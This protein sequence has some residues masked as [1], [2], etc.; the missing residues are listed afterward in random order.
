MLVYRYNRHLFTAELLTNLI[1]QHTVD[2]TRLN[3]R[4]ENSFWHTEPSY[5]REI[6]VL[7][8]RIKKI[9]CRGYAC[10]GSDLAGQ[11]ISKQIRSQ[12]QLLGVFKLLGLVIFKIHKLIY[13]IKPHKLRAGQTVQ[14]IS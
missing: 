5:K 11:H 4:R 13:C 2:F 14:L 10:L 8:Y 6:P 12:K 7:F 1:C 3:N 9:C